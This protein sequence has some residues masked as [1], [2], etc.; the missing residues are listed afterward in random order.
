MESFLFKIDVVEGFDETRHR[1]ELI[2]IM[3]AMI[4]KSVETDCKD[5]YDG[6]RTC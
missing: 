3:V 2:P 1:K 5:Y 4:M 6:E